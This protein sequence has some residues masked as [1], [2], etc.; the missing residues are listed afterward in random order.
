MK[1]GFHY[2]TPAYQNTHGEIWMEGHHGLFLDSLAAENEEIVC[3]LHTP[4]P[5]EM[6]RM[7]YCIKSPNIKLVS[8]PPHYHAIKRIFSRSTI[9][10]NAAK[11]FHGLD[12][13]IL[14]GPSPLLPSFA[15]QLVKHK[16]PYSF[17][18]VGDY[19]KSLKGAKVSF[20]KRVLLWI[21]YSWNKYLQDKFARNCMVVTNSHLIKKEYAALNSNIQSIATTTI[22]KKDIYLKEP[23]LSG[24]KTVHLLYAGRLESSK[25]L[26]ELLIAIK[27]LNNNK[28]DCFLDIVGWEY[29]NGYVEK[30]KKRARSFNVEEKI[31]FHGIKPLKESLFN[32]YKKAD[33]FISPSITSEGFPK[34]IWEAMAHSVPVI[35]TTVGAIP[36]Y[37]HD[38]KNALL[39]K[40]RSPHAIAH[41]VERLAKNRDLR[42]LITNNALTL[43]K[44][45]TLESES[46]RMTTYLKDFVGT[47]DKTAV[48]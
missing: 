26:D 20:Y 11:N 46:V 6:D 17:L 9:T 14:R 31:T 13:F 29:Q 44:K 23:L 45:S 27:T 8:L 24:E 4:L 18:L 10:R 19:L 39:V 35:A 3:F 41:A 36:Y 37:L 48:Q 16:I 1:I 34:T 22:H 43:V 30:L 21:Y 28:I 47:N 12:V 2:H 40:P 7:N 5:E 42:Q 25:G 38:G 33:I 15:F 32:M